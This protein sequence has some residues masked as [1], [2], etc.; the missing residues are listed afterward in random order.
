MSVICLH[1]FARILPHCVDGGC[2]GHAS[3]EIKTNVQVAL[4]LTKD[5]CLQCQDNKNCLKTIL[6]RELTILVLGSIIL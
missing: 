6:R 5:I 1:L 3:Q 4:D 2:R